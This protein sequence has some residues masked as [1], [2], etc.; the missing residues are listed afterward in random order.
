MK[1]LSM[2]DNDIKISDNP[3]AQRVTIESPKRAE[4]IRLFVPN[5]GRGY[6]MITYES[7]KK[8]K[9]LEGAYLSRKAALDAVLRFLETAKQSTYANHNEW[10][11][12]TKNKRVRKKPVEVV[13]TKA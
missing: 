6:W 11:G 2:D 8:I 5:N 9:G 1:D 3:E 4:K 12:Q 7:G 13:K 10:F